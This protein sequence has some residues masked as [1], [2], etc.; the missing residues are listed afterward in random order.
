MDNHN[1]IV[2][3]AMSDYVRQMEWGMHMHCMSSVHYKSNDLHAQSFMFFVQVWDAPKSAQAKVQKVCIFFCVYRII[4]SIFWYSSFNG[5]SF[6]N[7]GMHKRCIQVHMFCTDF[8]HVFHFSVFWNICRTYAQTR[9][10]FSI[11]CLFFNFFHFFGP[12][13]IVHMQDCK[14]GGFL[15]AWF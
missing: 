1:L 10:T 2:I 6:G 5:F 4:R 3:N 15:F 8:L 12:A 11:C 14:N 7:I 9:C 13:P